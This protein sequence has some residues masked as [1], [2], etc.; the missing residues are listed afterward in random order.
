M[1][2]ASNYQSK[3]NLVFYNKKLSFSIATILRLIALSFVLTIVS[4]SDQLRLSYI[5][6]VKIY[7]LIC[8]IYSLSLFSVLYKRFLTKLTFYIPIQIILDIFLTSYLISFTGLNSSVFVSLYIINIVIA[9]LGYRLLI[10][11]PVYCLISVIYALIYWFNDV[12]MSSFNLTS[13]IY[14]EFFF[15]LTQVLSIQLTTRLKANTRNF[16]NN[17]R[18]YNYLKIL[19]RKLVDNLPTGIMQI[20]KDD[21]VVSLNKAFLDIFNFDFMPNQKVL[22]YDL[23]PELVNIRGEWF[24]LTEE[25]KLSYV[26]RIP[27][28]GNSVKDVLL[29][30]VEVKNK[31]NESSGQSPNRSECLF[32]FNDISEFKRVEKELSD[33]SK[34]ITIGRFAAG[35]A[36]EIQTPLA[37]ISGSVE[38]IAENTGI[39]DKGDKD[40][41]AITVKE[42]KRL[43]AFVQEFLDYS[44]LSYKDTSSDVLVYDLVHK[45]VSMMKNSTDGASIT[46]HIDVPHDLKL[47]GNFEKLKQVF[48]NLYSNSIELR[49][50]RRANIFIKARLVDEKFY[51]EVKDDGIGVPDNI[52]HKTFDPFVATQKKGFGP[53]SV[54]KIVRNFVMILTDV[55]TVNMNGMELL[56]E[57]KKVYPST[58]VTIVTAYASE[59]PAVDA[60]K[61]GASE[62]LVKPFQRERLLDCVEQ[63]LESISIGGEN[64][65][66]KS[67]PRSMYSF[68]DVIGVSDKMQEVFALIKQVA[69][70][71]SNVLI[72]GESGTGKELVARLIH[73]YGNFPEKNAPF[74]AINCGAVQESLLESEMF[75]HKKGAFT[76]AE[77]DKKGLF[78]IA[79]DGTL[80]LDE[81]SELT[82]PIQVKLLRAIQDRTFRRVGGIE[83]ISVDVRFISAS[84]IPLEKK[85]E[86]GQFRKDLFYRLDVIK[87]SLPPLRQRVEDIPLLANYFCKKFSKQIHKTD[88]HISNEAMNVLKNY[89]FTGNV[90]ELENII[91][92]AMAV[93]NGSV[94]SLEDLPPKVIK[95]ATLLPIDTISKDKSLLRARIVEV[96][97]DGFNLEKRIVEHE[98]QYIREAMKQAKGAR[99]Q[100]AKILGISFR[101]LRYRLAKFTDIHKG[102]EELED[103]DFKGKKSIGF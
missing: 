63:S 36:H 71:G 14:H 75:G 8:V 22:Y 34:L 73:S 84:N 17:R 33:K 9:T 24:S 67:I 96:I 58:A 15:F 99:T 38:T 103:S 41:V 43:D 77:Y 68:D 18:N 70:S 89:S 74:V 45:V 2:V 7:S 78:E 20:D 16:I 100:A 64:R 86:L 97:P 95:S 57:I 93:C 91:E 23:V 44:K 79:N 10:S 12:E 82:L 28:K 26:I 51:M 98:K 3:D 13:L 85:V 94:I 49:K 25:E 102:K 4:L 35:V 1:L 54:E 47:V 60:I 76:G 90:R 40:L 21:F 37:P 27:I 87:I 56:L 92:R 62:H 6:L 31:K 72:E 59:E 66:S 11:I 101:S 83:D 46:F 81:V 61:K 39:F 52:I 53:S 55:N 48:F 88:M 32:I 65:R 69:K 5:E 42:V 19:N 30:V 29:R 80:F 50:D